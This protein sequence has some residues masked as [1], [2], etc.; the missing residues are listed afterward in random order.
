MYVGNHKSQSDGTHYIVNQIKKR[1]CHAKLH[2]TFFIA[3]V[4]Y[5]GENRGHGGCMVWVMYE[6]GTKVPNLAPSN[7]SNLSLYNQVW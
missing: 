6:N 3:F 2:E 7:I 5:I 1:E 4:L